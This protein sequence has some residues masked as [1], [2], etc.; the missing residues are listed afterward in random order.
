MRKASS[1]DPAVMSTMDMKAFRKLF[2][3]KFEKREPSR[4][5]IQFGKDTHPKKP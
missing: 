5:R 1:S 2:R 4:K 3:E